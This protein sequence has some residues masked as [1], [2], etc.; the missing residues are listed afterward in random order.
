MT[1]SWFDGATLEVSFTQLKGALDTVVDADFTDISAY[2]RDAI[3]VNRGRGSETDSFNTGTMQLTLDNRDRRFDPEYSAGPY[4]GNLLPMRHVRLRLTYSGSTSYLFHGF[5]REWSQGWDRAGTD[6][7]CVLTVDDAMKVLAFTKLPE[8]IYYAEVV[9]DTPQAW[10]RLSDESTATQMTDF[11]GNGRHGLYELTTGATHERTTG[12]IE[13]STDYAR[14]FTLP[15]T[16]FGNT[17]VASN[18]DAG[19]SMA[20]VVG[21]AWSWEMW[22]VLPPVASYP[23][24]S[25]HILWSQST[26]LGLSTSGTTY[27]QVS[28]GQN[29]DGTRYIQIDAKDNIPTTGSLSYNLSTSLNDN[30]RHHFA[31]TRNGSTV[32]F[33]IDGVAQTAASSSGSFSA[34]GVTYGSFPS[35]DVNGNASASWTYDEIATYTYALSAARVLAHYQAGTTAYAGDVISARITRVMA[36]A[37]MS[38]FPVSIDTSTQ[39]V[40][41]C[42]F[43][44]GSISLIAYL[45]T[46]ERTENGRLFISADG[47][48][49]FHSRYHDAGRAVATAFSDVAG[50]TLPYADLG[51]EYNDTRIIND[52]LVTRT[53]GVTQRV[54][55]ATSKTSFGT[56]SVQVDGLAA[57]S[58]SEMADRAQA[59]VFKY[60]DPKARFT[61]VAVAPRAAP[62]TLFPVVRVREVGD[63]VSVRRLPVGT[64]SAFTKELTVEG[65][66]HRIDVRGTWVTSYL[67]APG[68]LSSVWLILDDPTYGQL[69]VGRLGF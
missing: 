18:R 63:R 46:L 17:R 12:L 36:A 49:T 52:A 60:K 19:G 66:S 23:N 9:A 15:S 2:V 67:T 21:G 20:F 33:Y 8:S 54:S 24:S 58:D 4:F 65:V 31:F 68:D 34:T 13:L 29:F 37:G 25:G 43:G 16:G 55:D 28:F 64:G 10:Y 11:S 42:D 47:T 26:A 7:V 40:R 5:A 3:S 35:F 61:S 14:K 30:S 50:T 32:A 62:T 1:V 48:L 51:H 45:Q 53:N 69:D 57:Q 41:G 59:I 44:G 22:A 27:F 38:S 39:T 6:A 56:R